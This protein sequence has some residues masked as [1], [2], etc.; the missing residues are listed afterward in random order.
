MKQFLLLLLAIVCAHA[1]P[2]DVLTPA[3]C[4][5]AIALGAAQQALNKINADRHEGYI[6]GLHRLSNVHE[7][8]HVSSHSKE[9]LDYNVTATVLQRRSLL[10][11]QCKSCFVSEFSVFFKSFYSPEIHE[12]VTSNS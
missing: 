7:M 1:A 6:F 3:S 9:R 8:K 10:T 2:V 11:V 4:K 5:D 12:G